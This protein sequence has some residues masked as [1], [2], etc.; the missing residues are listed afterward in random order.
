MRNTKIFLLFLITLFAACKNKSQL[1]VTETSFKEEVPLLGN[2]TFTFNKDLAPDSV[3]NLW[4]AGKYIDFEPAISG[5]FMWANPSV[6]IFSPEA[7]LTP[8]TTY[9][10]TF[11]KELTKYHKVYSVDGMDEISFRT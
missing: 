4:D 2:L 9:K 10:G 11:T 7:S 8:A 5:K 1:N 3:L 6:L